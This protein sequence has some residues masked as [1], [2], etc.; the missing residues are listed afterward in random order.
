MLKQALSIKWNKRIKKSWQIAWNYM[1]FHM[2]SSL[3]DALLLYIPPEPITINFKV[4]INHIDRVKVNELSFYGDI[5]F[6]AYTGVN[7]S[8]SFAF[9]ADN[10]TD[11]KSND[12]TNCPFGGIRCLNAMEPSVEKYRDGNLPNIRYF[13]E[14]DSWY[15]RGNIVGTFSKLFDLHAYP[16]DV[17]EIEFIFALNVDDTIAIF[18]EDNLSV[19]LMPFKL[20]SMAGCDYNVYQPQISLIENSAIKGGSSS[21]K[22]YTHC[23]VIIPISRKYT[24]YIYDVVI[25]LLLIDIVSFSVYFTDLKPITHRLIISMTLLLTLFAFKWSIAN[26][27]P[28]TPYL[29]L[30]DLLFNSAYLLCGL[31]IFGLCIANQ[32]HEN[33]LNLIC[34]IITL[35]IFIIIHV[36]LYFRAKNYISLYPKEDDVNNNNA[37][38]VIAKS[39]F[40]S[41]SIKSTR[42]NSFMSSKSN[43]DLEASL[44]ADT[45]L[46]VDE[47]IK[48]EI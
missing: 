41:P 2:K 18:N 29:T 31:H 13:E 36:L 34:A 39:A 26:S 20:D 32:L 38:A 14:D 21:G 33:Q 28:P 1:T 45:E 24:H 37:L 44:L 27:L 42:A 47:Q 48:V 23:K 22:R 16:F 25:P 30:T 19:R 10:Y 35:I 43:F 46:V 17:H 8:Q 12:N 15:L 3:E 5:W 7:P 9:G 4:L 40:N 11:N 6:A